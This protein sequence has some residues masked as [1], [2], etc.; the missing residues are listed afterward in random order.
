MRAVLDTNVLI[1]ATLVKGGVESRIVRAWQ[2]GQFDLVLS[3]DILEEIGRAMRYE[4]LANHRW[5]LPEEVTSFIRVL[6]QS[7]V[8]VSGTVPIAVCRDPDDDKFLAAAI[9]GKAPWVVSGDRDLLAVQRHKTVSIVRPTTF[10]RELQ[11]KP[12]R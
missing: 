10:L 2:A 6:A 5:M 4:K 7:A 11:A 9:E 3:P 1:S 12:S 8:L